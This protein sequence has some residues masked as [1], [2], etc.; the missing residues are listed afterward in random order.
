MNPNFR[1]ILSAFSGHQVEYL[2]VGAFALAAHGYRRATGDIDLWVNP[3]EANAKRVYAAL[4]AFGAP[5]SQVTV[6]D[7]ATPN[8][9]FQIGVEPQRIDILTQ[10]SG[11]DS[12]HE[13]WASR[14]EV[15]LEDLRVPYL[16]RH[17]LIQNK[18]ATD[19]PKDRNDLLWLLGDS[20]A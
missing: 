1:D 14:E 17:H 6:R 5:L 18:R 16:S 13:A 15:A 20:D 8:I 7:F 12:F 9:I 4:G 19:R 2:L 3:T 11:L 10:L